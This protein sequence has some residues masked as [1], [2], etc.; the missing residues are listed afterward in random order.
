MQASIHGERTLTKLD[1]AR[2]TKLRGRQVP[3]ALTDLLTDADVLD[4]TEIPADIVTMYTQVEIEDIDTR[5]LRTLVLCY[6][7]D[8][9]PSAGFISVL[10]PVGISL[11]GLKTGSVARWQSPS[12]EGAAAKVI[13][14]RFQPEASGDYTT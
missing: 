14:L 13:A 2:L 4:S 9:E 5:L 7:D 8:A 11:L 10:S 3:P 12:G 1:F 6:P